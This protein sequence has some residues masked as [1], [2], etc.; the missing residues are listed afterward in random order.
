MM[1]TGQEAADK[2]GI[3]AVGDDTASATTAR[4]HRKDG[5]SRND[6]GR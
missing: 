3:V 5:F 1:A 4:D 6:F 2:S